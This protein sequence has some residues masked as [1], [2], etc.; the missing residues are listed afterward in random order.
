MWAIF[1][2]E[3]RA[4]FISSVGYIVIGFFLLMSGIFF[5]VN[6]VLGATPDFK[7]VLGSLLFIFL[8][9]VPILTMRLIAEDTRSKTDQMLITSPV[10]ITAIV[11]GK[12]LAALALF[13]IALSI[14][15]V[16][17]IIMSVHS[18]APLATME[19]LG[20]Y[21]GFFLLGSAFIAVG[22]FISS[23]TENP[24][25]AAMA[26]FATLLVL[27]IIDWIQPSLPKDALSGILFLSMLGAG[28]VLVVHIT[29][30]SVLATA[31]LAAGIAVGLGLSYALQGSLYKGIIIRIVGWFSLVKRFQDFGLGVLSLSPI[32]YYLSFS[33]IFVFFTVRMIEKR[34]WS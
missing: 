19:I 11:L 2:R 17:P 21:I 16:Y 29:I 14:T 1:W 24:I 12:Y 20:G 15:I 34:R 7:T 33:A 27:W 31:G 18:M 32:V 26:T 9:I 22:L 28:I 10:R 25:S 8:F 6:N 3:L 23:L 5:T 30:R 4:Y 13:G